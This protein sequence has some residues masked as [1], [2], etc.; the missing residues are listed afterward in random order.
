MS[1]KLVAAK[2]KSPESTATHFVAKGTHL[3][4]GASCLK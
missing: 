2:T 4:K 1:T 3:G